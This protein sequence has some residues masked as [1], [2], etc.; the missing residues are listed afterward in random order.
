MTPEIHDLVEL[1]EDLPD[2]P[3][4][5]RGTVVDVLEHASLLVEIVGPDGSTL[6]LVEIPSSG[7]RLSDRAPELAGHR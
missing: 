7:V 2:W 3:A 5:T 1:V 4:G 6:D